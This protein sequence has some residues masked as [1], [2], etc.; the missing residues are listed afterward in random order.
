MGGGTHD[1]LDFDA[2]RRARAL[3]REYH[4]REALIIRRL[5]SAN[6][7]KRDM[8]TLYAVVFIGVFPTLWIL[9]TVFD[10]I[11]PDNSGRYSP[12]ET[13]DEDRPLN[14]EPLL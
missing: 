13:M 5:A 8:T 14:R 3:S 1:R 12:R 9:A 7:G 4:G 10:H 11:M 6:W 2:A